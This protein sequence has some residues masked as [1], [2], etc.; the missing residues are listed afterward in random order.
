MPFKQLA[1]LVMAP[2]RR[3]RTRLRRFRRAVAERK[4]VR[5]AGVNVLSGPMLGLTLIPATAGL[6]PKLLGTF[7]Q[8][9]W[10]AIDRILRIA[11]QH[12]VSIGSAEGYY[13]IGLLRQL[14]TAHG[15]AFETLVAHRIGMQ[16][17][18][19]INQIGLDRLAIHGTCDPE[20]LRATL[21]RT[22]F[23]RTVAIVDVE[24][25]ER[26]LLDL[27]RIPTLRHTFVLVEVH[28]FVDPQ[29]STLL[30]ERFRTTHTFTVYRSRARR[31]EDLPAVPGMGARLLMRAAQEGRPTT[32][33]WFWF[34]PHSATARRPGPPE[35]VPRRE[36]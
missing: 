7:E 17:M 2:I 34:E 33:E 18:A 9:I 13:P 25:A 8:E 19:R 22:E 20:A 30:R 36:A 35:C 24:G 12:I 21:Q 10:P 4:L 6:G 28:D 32:M 15:S 31:I 14:S 5:Q 1:R 27:D 26:E 3:E 29:I 11:P 16:E 23:E